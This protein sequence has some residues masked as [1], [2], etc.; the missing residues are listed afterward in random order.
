M[1]QAAAGQQ[2]FGERT[3]VI[4]LGADLRNDLFQPAGIGIRPDRVDG[5]LQQGV[6]L[7]AE[8]FQRGRIGIENA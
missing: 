3:G 2:V 4:A 6:A 8:E 1:A 5:L 7:P